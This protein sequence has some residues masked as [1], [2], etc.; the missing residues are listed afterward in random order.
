MSQNPW[1]QPLGG[2]SPEG[3]NDSVREY[4]PGTMPEAETIG[5]APLSP[6]PTS[7]PE[8][9]L[10]PPA[11][12]PVPGESPGDSD[13]NIPQALAEPQNGSNSRK[14]NWFKRSPPSR[15]ESSSTEND[16]ESAVPITAGDDYP[17]AENRPAEE[18]ASYNETAGAST[19]SQAAESSAPVSEAAPGPEPAPEPQPQASAEGSGGKRWFERA[20]SRRTEETPPLA[21]P[22]EVAAN[23]ASDAESAAPGEESPVTWGLASVGE[24]AEASSQAA[25]SPAP[26]SE[27][28]PGPEPA[29]EPQ[30]QASAEGS[31]GKRWFERASSRRT[32]ETPPLATPQEVAANPALN[33][34]VETSWG[35]GPADTEGQGGPA[36]ES[37]GWS[38][39]SPDPASAST[40]PEAET[41]QQDMWSATDAAQT[42]LPPSGD[43]G[44]SIEP[45]QALA[46]DD[47]TENLTT[48]PSNTPR[49]KQSWLRRALGKQDDRGESGGVEQEGTSAPA[50]GPE[51]APMAITGELPLVEP[52]GAGSGDADEAPPRATQQHL[53]NVDSPEEQSASNGEVQE[54]SPNP[55]GPQAATLPVTAAPPIREPEVV[56][57]T[58][59]E[60]KA[61]RDLINAVE[62]LSRQPPSTARIHLQGA[63]GDIRRLEEAFNHLLARNYAYYHALEEAVVKQR[64]FVS[65]ASH[66]LRTPLTT[67]AS[68][69][70]ILYELPDMPAPQR[71]DLI[72]QAFP[73]SRRM[74]KLIDDLLLL[75]SIDSGEHLRS[76]PLVWDDILEHV[77]RRA[78]RLCAPRSIVLDAP[79]R[80]GGGYGDVSGIQKILDALIDN[81]AGHTGPDCTVTIH[82]SREADRVHFSVSDDGDGV[83]DEMLGMLFNRFSRNDP[84]R[85]GSGNGLGLAVAAAIVAA[86]RGQISARHNSPSGLT[87]DVTLPSHR[88][89]RPVSTRP[90]GAGNINYSGEQPTE[91]N[92]DAP[93]DDDRPARRLP[94]KRQKR[95]G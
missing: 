17:S 8:Y 50:D 56:D 74:A 25:E 43:P 9:V 78:H 30:Q 23:P 76:E 68:C 92:P 7:Q 48:P 34:P 72:N 82:A 10:P 64:R 79:S 27:A 83:S 49:P 16:S 45:S 21:T 26:V 6:S 37:S 91:E 28:A 41:R 73:E 22:Q 86:H 19:S 38:A 24:S 18:E 66:E 63:S 87:V 81:V 75:A 35:I 39:K 71:H 59:D 62:T 46:P 29:P 3:N 51:V 94:W 44:G 69:L 89:A 33:E 36:E 55:P 58:S 60:L 54:T 12:V 84:S 20:S 13:P 93:P 11:N 4:E 1:A 57:L 70:E 95:S 61:V 65:D 47:S 90:A 77:V 31:G 80:L 5:E 40:V 42:S 88:T 32:E 2:A 85:H 52:T 15:T 53:P 14:R 67:I